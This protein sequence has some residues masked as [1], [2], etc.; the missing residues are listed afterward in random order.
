MCAGSHVGIDFDNYDFRAWAVGRTT[1]KSAS[2]ADMIINSEIK[3]LMRVEPLYNLLA[4]ML[5]RDPSKRPT[6]KQCLERL[7][8]EWVA[9][10][11]A[12]AFTIGEYIPQDWQEGAQYAFGGSFEPGETVVVRRSDGSLRFGVIKS[13]GLRGA[14]DV[15]VEESGNFQRGVASATLGKIFA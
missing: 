7:G 6:A 2:Y 11:N 4:D 14:V 12:M 15:T 13:L 3:G 1:D 10:D 9:R 5:D 8:Q